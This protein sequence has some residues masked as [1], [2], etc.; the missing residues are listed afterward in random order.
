MT[1]KFAVYAAGLMACSSFTA[2]AFAQDAEASAQP[3][4]P[5]NV[6]I[7]TATRRASDVQDI[8][9]AVTAVT[10]Q[11][12]EQQGIANIQ[13][14]GA[15]SASFNIQSS[16]TESQGTS[17]RLRGVG[18]TGN[19]IGLESAVGVFIDGVYQSRPGIALG[20][21]VDVAQLEVLRGPQGT[22]FGRN[23]TAGA[24]VVRHKLPELDEFGGEVTATYG[25]FD[26][27]NVQGALNAPLVED[28]LGVRFSGSYRQRDGFVTNPFNGTES[29]D[30]DR[31]LLR[32]QLLWEPSADLSLRLIADYQQTD[33]NC[34]DSVTLRPATGAPQAVSDALFPNG[35]QAPGTLTTNEFPFPLDRISNSQGFENDIEQWGVSAELNWDLG[36]AD[37]TIIG[38]YRDFLGE[39]RQDDFNGGLV[40]S[41]SGSTFPAGTPPTFDDIKTWT[42]EGR[43]QGDAFDGV[44]DWLVG[45]FYS[46]EQIVEEFA[47]GLGPEFG[48][49]IGQSFG[50]PG[51]ALQGV[52]DAGSIFSNGVLDPTDAAFA[53]GAFAQ[54]P[55]AAQ[56]S[57]NRFEQEGTSFSVF[58][59][60]IF[61]VTDELSI[62]L[63]ARYV[64]DQKD[65]RYDQLSSTGNACAAS[66]AFFGGLQQA[67]GAAAGGD[68]AG[69]DAI[70]GAL[71]PI[72]GPAGAGALQIPA[73][74]GAGA[75]LNCFVFAAPADPFGG[76]NPATAGLPVEFD[77]TFTDDE[78]IYTAQV[79][80]EPNADL[81]LYAGFTHGYK[82]GG[83]NLDA[84]A[85]IGGADP[86]FRSEEI[87]AYE[88]GLK[89]TLLDGRARANI[90]LFYSDLA[91]FQ[92]LEFTGTQFQTFNV[93]DVSSKGI[94]L[95]LF[96]QWT[97]YIS[98]TV[99]VTYTDAQYGA[100]CDASLIAAG[101]ANPAAGLCGSSL[102]NAPEIVGIFGMT[103]DGP[104]SGGGWNML[105]NA[106]LRYESDRRTSTNPQDGLGLI[107]F[108]V[109][110]AN[111]KLNL[112]LGFTDP[113][114]T[115]TIELWG[116][117][118]T[119][120]VT[121]AITFNT[122][123]VGS[124]AAGT[125]GRSAFL[126]EPRTYGVTVR[127][128]F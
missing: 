12:L 82:A 64:D 81:L 118:V 8:P 122:P 108:D 128:K 99:A 2:P 88:I 121:R 124:V 120:E 102:T 17:I 18:T 59:H 31:F 90:A 72:F 71:A 107:P 123:L 27:I 55:I 66:R 28:S 96:A 75:A 20:E 127:A 85:A 94:E 109:Q 54:S 19:N 21:L 13:T 79:G 25:N 58:T 50:L 22:L 57:L 4:A 110:D 69:L 43:L 112:R 56:S 77:D 36:G 1:K 53:Q 93:D 116:R 114:D 41:V 117:N 51:F 30:R 5:D 52:A 78:F 48:D 24:L 32:G 91:D 61:N 26:L 92:V 73:I 83:F 111:A 63:G 95:E 70:N 33:E 87:D 60:N 76:T 6:I 37:L 84:S 29:N 105:A 103:Y 9:I 44:V 3:E 16:Q 40:Y 10:P 49:L 101:G 98:N 126:E 86:R 14:L 11:Q 38:S 80:Y 125:E 46:D 97:D 74:A 39:S 42:V 23:T 62:T 119:N 47:L 15:V 65:A 113:S 100:N 7:V 45:V 115:Y 89:S 104:I 35:T 106:N 34:C 68:T 67:L